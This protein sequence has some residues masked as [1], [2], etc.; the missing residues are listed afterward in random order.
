[1]LINTYEGGLAGAIE[2]EAER[3]DVGLGETITA[4][5]MD[6]RRKQTDDPQ[7]M[8][9]VA[10]NAWQAV[11]IKNLRV[12]NPDIDAQK[13]SQTVETIAE[14]AGAALA[15]EGRGETIELPKGF[16]SPTQIVEELRE[17]AAHMGDTGEDVDEA[18]AE[19]LETM[20]EKIADGIESEH[21]LVC[22]GL[23][24]IEGLKQRGSPRSVRHVRGPQ[25]WAGIFINGS[26]EEDG[27]SAQDLR[28]A[29]TWARSLEPWAIVGCEGEADERGAVRYVLFR[30]DGC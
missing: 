14:L 17:L 6:P 30:E 18:G 27:V 15:G 1:M 2:S 13:I 4:I 25:E 5:A 7:H 11:R 20:L 22:E 16:D 29:D 3:W 24:D 10:I 9:G 19:A 12:P 8:V 21:T 28:D 26:G 23:E